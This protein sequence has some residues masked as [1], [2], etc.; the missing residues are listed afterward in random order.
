MKCTLGV[1]MLTV[2]IAMGLE[3]PGEVNNT[4]SAEL[5]GALWTV[6]EMLTSCWRVCKKEPTS[7]E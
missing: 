1:E 6:L 3:S 5:E 4:L 7:Y 2:L